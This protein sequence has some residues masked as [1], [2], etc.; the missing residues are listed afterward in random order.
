MMTDA[1]QQPSITERIIDEVTDAQYTAAQASE[2]L[3]IAGAQLR[4]A[5]AQ[6]RSSSIVTTIEACTRAHPLPAVITA[7]MLGAYVFR[8]R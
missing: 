6:T 3:R 5:V 1:S 8:R 7:F 2:R 4:A